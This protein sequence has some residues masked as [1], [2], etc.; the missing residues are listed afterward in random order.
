MPDV[1]LKTPREEDWYEF[2]WAGWLE[3]DDSIVSYTVTA[4]PGLVVDR[5]EQIDDQIRFWV[6]GGVANQN[7]VV[8]CLVETGQGR[9][10]ERWLTF[11]VR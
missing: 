3:P 2:N 5:I 10:A 11:L 9:I 1:F 4:A 7:Y 8:T 6:S